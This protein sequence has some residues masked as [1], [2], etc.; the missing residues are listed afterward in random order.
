MKLFAGIAKAVVLVFLEEGAEVMAV[1]VNKE[2]LDALPKH[3]GMEHIYIYIQ[4]CKN[5]FAKARKTHAC[6]HIN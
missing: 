4:T 1:D 6:V 5:A 3:S 2:S